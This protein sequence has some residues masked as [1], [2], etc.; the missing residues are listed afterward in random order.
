MSFSSYTGPNRP[1]KCTDVPWALSSCPMT[2]PSLS[3]LVAHVKF[4]ACT[5]PFSNNSLRIWFTCMHPFLLCTWTLMLSYKHTHPLQNPHCKVDSVFF[6]PWWDLNFE[7]WTSP[8]LGNFLCFLHLLPLSRQWNI[9]CCS[10]WKTICLHQHKPL[11]IC[12]KCFP[13]ICGVSKV[14]EQAKIRLLLVATSWALKQKDQ[15]K[16]SSTLYM[17]VLME[18]LELGGARHQSLRW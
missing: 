16:V 13:G 5:Y 8:W 15:E 7:P 4:H 6:F 17:S 12:G 18:S 3:H 2:T 11:I 10:F 9:C 14:V 1:L